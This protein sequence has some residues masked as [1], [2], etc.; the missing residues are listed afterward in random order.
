MGK[1]HKL[2][3]DLVSKIAAGEVIER[4][5]FAVKELIENALD[6]KATS[7]KIS[8]EDAGLSR[9]VVS[10]N[11]LGM[12]KDDLAESIK[13]H[14]TSKLSSE[15]DLGN[16]KSLGFRGEALS[17]ISSISKLI[18][19]SRQKNKISGYE[20]SNHQKAKA[21]GMNVGTVV[22][23]EH[24]FH[25]VPAR[26]KFLKTKKTEYRH[27]LDV[28]T[29]YVLS[30][31]NVSFELN[32]NGS[33]VFKF[34]SKD[35]IEKRI[36][37]LFGEHVFSN[38]VSV[39]G[40]ESYIKLSGFMSRP[41]LSYYNAQKIFL[42]INNRPVYDPLI[43]SAIKEAY[44]NMLE[45]G[46]Y[47]FSVLFI[48]LPPETV[49]V[50]VHP[51]KEHV[52]FTEPNE[53]YFAINSSIRDFLE[54]NN[55]TFHNLSWKEKTT[56]TKA[57]VF[58]RDYI[59]LT[60]EGK[61]GKAK[62][63]AKFVQLH[64]LYIAVETENG[65]MFIDQ[66]AAHEAVLYRKLLDAYKNESKK[67]EKLKLHKSILVSFPLSDA[68]IVNENKDALRNI[69]FEI[70]EFGQGSIRINTIPKLID[71]F[72]IEEIF[73]EFIDDLRDDVKPK[74]ISRKANKMLSY[75]ACRSSIKAG[76]SLEKEDIEKLVKSLNSEDYIYTCPHGRPVK[77]EFSLQALDK[78]FKRK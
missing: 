52:R 59:S 63:E 43:N 57:A 61:I 65:V 64:N 45:H 26:K 71:G 2:P 4:P 66:H 20:V 70:E 34:T 72:S 36:E 75:L 30:N 76:Q 24:L 7:V 35:N 51:R 54:K 9:I 29:N 58:L 8:I 40:S 25:N 13:P 27:I 55:L 73:K 32:N 39:S 23:V 49:D 37:I 42:F 12:D 22:T 19:Q 21:V 74:K 48:K 50:N 62:R 44:G 28:V 38:L 60:A 46:S 33:Q 68:V 69:G 18:I 17:S 41:Q 78:L 3:S 53:V 31:P 10:D 14:T 67:S 6:A 11:G 77:I 56:Q 15:E 5:A 16:I 1:I 47:P